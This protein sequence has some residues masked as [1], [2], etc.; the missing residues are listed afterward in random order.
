[1]RQYPSPLYLLLLLLTACATP[2]SL[3]VG[4]VFKLN[5][6]Q[7]AEVTVSD[8]A[9]PP[10][11]P[12]PAKEVPKAALPVAAQASQ[13]LPGKGVSPAA[14]SAQAA[15][16]ALELAAG[17]TRVKLYFANPTRGK[18]GDCPNVYFVERDVF[19]VPTIGSSTLVELM[20]GPTDDEKAVGYRS[21]FAPSAR[22]KGLAIRGDLAEV[23]FEAGMKAT[24][25]KCATA[26]LRHQ[27][28]STM[29]QFPAVK[30]VGITS[31]VSVW[32]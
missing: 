11:P 18:N 17:M 19:T 4:P 1:M 21:Y 30:R 25:D 31:G 12:A 23:A 20:K 5:Q 9:V 16:T 15:Y 7:R 28:V 2:I 24:D 22:L 29:M 32:K 10:R 8:T 26:T 27:I 14:A 3:C 6:G 13:A